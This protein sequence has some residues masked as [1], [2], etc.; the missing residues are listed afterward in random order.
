MKPAESFVNGFNSSVTT[1]SVDVRHAVTS[2]D[3]RQ[4]NIVVLCLTPKYFRNDNCLNE[5]RLCEIYQKQT[6]VC[7]VRHMDSYRSH[8]QLL[9]TSM[10]LEEQIMNF[11]SSRLPMT[12]MNYLRKSIRQCCIDLSTDELFSRNASILFQRLETL[13]GISS[14]AIGSTSHSTHRSGFVQASEVF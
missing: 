4:S 2:N 13:S 8:Q 10:N 14:N 6:I 7:L 1:S 3:M 11:V 5:L 12:T 9:N